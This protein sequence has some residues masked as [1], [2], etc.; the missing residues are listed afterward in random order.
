[1]VFHWLYR[2]PNHVG[3]ISKYIP[4]NIPQKRPFFV[5]LYEY[6]AFEFWT[7][8]RFSDRPWQTHVF[9]GL[10]PPWFIIPMQGPLDGM[11]GKPP[12]I[13]MSMP[14]K[15]KKTTDFPSFFWI[16]YNLWIQC[17]TNNNGIQV[18]S[19][20]PHYNLEM[21]SKKR[22]YLP[23]TLSDIIGILSDI[24]GYHGISRDFLRHIMGYNGS[25]MGYNG[26]NDGVTNKNEDV[27]S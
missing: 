26:E 22:G 18:F 27:I 14:W 21:Y 7:T 15:T 3:S 20:F 19:M 12:T 2:S 9:T 10:T 5:V 13:S 25:V 11:A 8:S 1:M 6:M 24:I 16:L 23:A 17:F 4:Q